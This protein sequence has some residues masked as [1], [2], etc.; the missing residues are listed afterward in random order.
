MV[1]CSLRCGSVV[2]A[3]FFKIG[4]VPALGIG[5][6]QRHRLLMSLQLDLI[7]AL[8][9]IFSGLAF[10]VIEHFL[11]HIRWGAG[12]ADLFRRYAT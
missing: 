4:V 1:R 2:V 10:Q 9:E 3:H 5:F 7:V 8:I 12:N 11:M 6:E